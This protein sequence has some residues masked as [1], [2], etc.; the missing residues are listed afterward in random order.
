MDKILERL[1]SILLGL[2]QRVSNLQ[3]RRAC[4]SAR[5]FL[6]DFDLS[7]FSDD[8]IMEGLLECTMKSEPQDIYNAIQRKHA[9]RAIWPSILLP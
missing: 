8:D 5:T 9:A 4:R 6:S 7:E 3:K 2:A 1:M